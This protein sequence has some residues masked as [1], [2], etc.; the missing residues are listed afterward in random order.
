MMDKYKNPEAAESGILLNH[1]VM[2]D[3]SEVVQSITCV[4][5]TSQLERKNYII[6]LSSLLM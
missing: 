6:F 4:L 2:S 1:P 3:Q 5:L